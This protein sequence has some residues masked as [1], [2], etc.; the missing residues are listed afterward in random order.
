MSALLLDFLAVG[1]GGA[2]GACGRYAVG[3]AVQAAARVPFP[4]GTLTVNVVGCMLF[5]ALFAGL[6]DRETHLRLQ[7]FLRTGILFALGL[8]SSP[9]GLASARTTRPTR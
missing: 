6:P 8:E 3:R 2:I 1:A 4:V 5:G 7:V 9:D